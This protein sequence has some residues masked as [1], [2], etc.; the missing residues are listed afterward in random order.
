MLTRL[1]LRTSLPLLLAMFALLF[2]LLLTSMHLPRQA[3][4]SKDSLHSYTQQ[5]LILMQSSLSDHLRQRRS[6]ELQVTLADLASL[7]GVLW[8]M[9]IDQ[10]QHIAA[11]TRLGLHPGRLTLPDGHKLEEM[12]AGDR[13]RWLDL[14]N[15]RYLVSYPLIAT[16]DQDK[17]R[18]YSLLVSL[19]YQQ[20]TRRNTSNDWLYLGQI[21]VLLLLLGLFLNFLYARLVTRRLARIGEVV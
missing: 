4:A 8:A 15:H 9:V 3:K 21:L 19:D 17:L 2:I 20:S 7:Q 5:I 18:Q 16:L 1:S 6:Q 11:A 14:G 13:P 10:H 12:L